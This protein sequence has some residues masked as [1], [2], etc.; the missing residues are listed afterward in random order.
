MQTN[1]I[2]IISIN[3]LPLLFAITMHEAAHGW[4]ANK[5]GDNTAKMLGR[6]SLNPL[7]HIDFF[8]TIVVP[9]MFLLLGSN[10]IFGWA[11]PVPILERKLHHVRRDV[12]L[13]ALA[14]PL[15]NL[16]MM[17][18]WLVIAKISLSFVA[19][20]KELLPFVLMGK[21]GIAINAM[22][23]ALNILPIPPLD[24]SKVVA[25]LLPPRL[26]YHYE[27]IGIYGLYI[28]II[29]SPFL[30]FLLSPIIQALWILPRKILGG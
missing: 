15:A 10:F 26:A 30:G 9:L 25:S 4:V 27:R 8:G 24:G 14:G 21:A 29:L 1:M 6:V 22:L 17:F 18:G 13:V 11:K 20:F 19:D 12:A 28:L 2:Q 23:I 16:L 5:C 3:L 7:R